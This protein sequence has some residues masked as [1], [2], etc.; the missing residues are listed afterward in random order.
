MLTALPEFHQYLRARGY[1]SREI[2]LYKSDVFLLSRWA[3]DRKLGNSWSHK[4]VKLYFETLK[5][6][7]SP[8]EIR[9]KRHTVA[10]Y[11]WFLYRTGSIDPAWYFR[12]SD[13]FTILPRWLSPKEQALLLAEVRQI[14]QENIK[15]AALIG[16]L[17]TTGLWPTQISDLKVKD[18]HHLQS[19]ELSIKGANTNFRQIHPLIYQVLR[20]YLVQRQAETATFLFEDDAGQP[21]SPDCIRKQVREIARQAGL[22]SVTVRILQHTCAKRIC[23]RDGYWRVLFYLGYEKRDR[24][25]YANPDAE[26]LFSPKK[27][28]NQYHPIQPPK[29]TPEYR[30]T[31]PL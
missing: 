19:T 8:S 31:K 24:Y 5:I 7:K 23:D 12:S 1:L 21:I 9:L 6:S 13:Q 22:K 3:E 29:D 25:A 2:R 4:M 30:P 18:I 14:A 15:I 26:L 16:L 20:E 27:G 11:L 28:F 17:F 10:T